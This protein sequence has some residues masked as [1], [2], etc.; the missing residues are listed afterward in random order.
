[1]PTFD[2]LKFEGARHHFLRGVVL[3]EVV[4]VA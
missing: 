2:E 4:V 3:A 1:M